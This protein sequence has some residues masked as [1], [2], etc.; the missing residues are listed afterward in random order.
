MSKNF[1][2]F[3]PSISP[4]NHGL[5]LPLPRGGRRSPRS[6]LSAFFYDGDLP[7]V[8]TEGYT[9][10]SISSCDEVGAPLENLGEEQP[11]ASH[12]RNSDNADKADAIIEHYFAEEMWLD[13]DGLCDL[14][15]EITRA[16]DLFFSSQ[17]R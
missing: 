7:T 2:N 14:K 8:G 6:R 10:D 16:L 3:S 5:L 12:G 15:G 1:H 13:K 4:D 17:I 9:D 11:H